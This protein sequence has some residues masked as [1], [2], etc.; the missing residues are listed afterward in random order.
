MSE[1]L[2]I[3]RPAT[4]SNRQRAHLFSPSSP[5]HHDFALQIQ[6]LGLQET[7]E[8]FTERLKAC[9]ERRPEQ[10][11]SPRHLTFEYE[12]PMYIRTPSGYA[13]CVL[14]DKRLVLQRIDKDSGVYGDLFIFTREGHIEW[15]IDRRF[16]VDMAIDLN[17]LSLDR[18]TGGRMIRRDI[19]SSLR[20]PMQKFQ[21][22]TYRM[23]KNEDHY[24]LI[25][26]KHR[27]AHGVRKVM[28]VQNY[29]ELQFASVDTA[30]LSQIEYVLYLP[31]NHLFSLTGKELPAQ[32]QEN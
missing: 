15:S 19:S 8:Q 4:L 9:P 7:G 22:L 12:V 6:E 2:L 28:H 31:S 13:L 18:H 21:V 25:Q 11:E 24:F 3:E 10:S 26:S 17:A 5:V 32:G 14:A 1:R 29:S 23:G 30:N 20:D 16:V 27:N